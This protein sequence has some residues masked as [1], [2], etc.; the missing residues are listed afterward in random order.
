MAVDMFLKLDG[1]KGE[2]QD[3]KHKDEIQILSFSWGLSQTAQGAGGGAG[4]SKVSV[5]DFQIVKR[6]DTASPQLMEM[7]CS[8]EHIGSG[9]L[10]LAK[11]GDNKGQQEY[12][13]IKFSDILISSYSTGGS[14]TGDPAEQISLNFSNV[15]VSAAEIKAD[16]SIGD[17]KNSTSCHF[18]GKR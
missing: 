2:S 11:A 4:A 12:M 8:G 14:N 7:A 5:S 9:L 16:G 3:S 10:T 15:E 17:W 18:G 1:V 13:K 6:L